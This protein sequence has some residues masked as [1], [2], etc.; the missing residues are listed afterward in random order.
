[1][2]RKNH[3][4]EQIIGKLREAEVHIS[5][6]MTVEAAAR[7]I[8]VTYQTYTRWRK[9]YGG[10]RTD[11]AKR[12][13]ELEKENLRLK[14]LVADKELDNQILREALAYDGKK[15]TAR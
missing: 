5:K 10:M 14:H 15:S 8:E 7:Q 6:G 4:P 11:Q 3:S 12:L 13:K 9:E 2:G 1:M